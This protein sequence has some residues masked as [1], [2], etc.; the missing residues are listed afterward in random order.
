MRQSLSSTTR[1]GS[2]LTVGISM[3]PASITGFS[4]FGGNESGVIAHL[5]EYAQ[6][7]LADAL[8]GISRITDHSYDWRLNGTVSP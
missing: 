5:K 6:G 4:D 1:R 2:G 3:F 7:G 8:T